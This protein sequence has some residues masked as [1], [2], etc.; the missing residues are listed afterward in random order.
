MTQLL[1]T[2]AT[3]TR[4]RLLIR[5]ARFGVEDY[6]RT[7]DLRRILR[8]QDLPGPRDALPRLMDLEAMQEA[9]RQRGD[10]AYSV[11]QHLEVLIALMAEARLLGGRT[12]YP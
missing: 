6:D 10:G 7:R 1:E 2:L 9:H 11:T 12:S 8:R 3:I 5:A 4:P